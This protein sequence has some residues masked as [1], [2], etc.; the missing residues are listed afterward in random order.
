MTALPEHLPRLLL[1]LRG[2]AVEFPG[3]VT[4]LPD[5][6]RLPAPAG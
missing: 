4:G 1:L 6:V 2:A 5:G 3:T